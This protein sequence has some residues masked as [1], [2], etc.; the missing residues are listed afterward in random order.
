M[1]NT[2]LITGGTKGIGLAAAQEMAGA[3]YNLIL[4]YNS[5]L[6][7][8]EEAKR[9]I[10][11]STNAAV[12]LYRLD[13]SDLCS[14]DTLK[15]YIIEN[16]IRLSG[17][18][19]NAGLTYRS[20]FEEMKMDEWLKVFNANIHFPVFF[21]QSILPGLQKGACIIFTGSLMGIYPH[22]VSLA[23]G[24]TKSGVHSLVENLVKFL[25]PYE[26]RVNA[27][28]PG[29]V[30]TEWQKNKPADIRRNIENKLSMHRFCSA[31]E[32]GEVY[33]FIFENKYFNG[34]I[35]TLSGGYSYK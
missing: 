26:I 6:N 13:I 35:V 23:Y 20:S 1:N 21:I 31:K 29:F 14:I 5:D 7:S 25:E 2:I 8:A 19:F 28:A 27:V 18:I 10:T 12:E 3:G 15:N 22:A 17:I 34:E 9:N 24:V 11:T 4:T 30:D 16:N 32:V 33:K